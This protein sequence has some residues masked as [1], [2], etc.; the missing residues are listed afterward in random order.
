MD[1]LQILDILFLLFLLLLPFLYV[2]LGVLDAFLE[3]LDVGLCEA[4]QVLHLLSV[5]TTLVLM[6]ELLG[7]DRY[8]L[9]PLAL[10]LLLGGIYLLDSL[11]VLH[12]ERL[13]SILALL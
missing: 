1:R 13:D 8:Q 3:L 9:L 7:A 11:F 4:D 5:S 10:T 6:V 12:I 2:S